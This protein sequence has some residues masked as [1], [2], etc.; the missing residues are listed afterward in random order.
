MEWDWYIAD[1]NGPPRIN[2]TKDDE[3][4]VFSLPLTE[5]NTRK[6]LAIVDILNGPAPY[7]YTDANGLVSLV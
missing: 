6:M 7:T 3:V 2:L 4:I 1:Q 5:D